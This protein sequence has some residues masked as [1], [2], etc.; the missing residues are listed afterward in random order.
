MADSDEEMPTHKAVAELAECTDLPEQVVPH[1]ALSLARN[2][3]I[4]EQA[5]NKYAVGFVVRRGLRFIETQTQTTLRQFLME[6]GDIIQTDDVVHLLAGR[7]VYRGNG[8]RQRKY[9]LEP[10]NADCDKFISAEM[11]PVLRELFRYVA[12]WE[13]DF[14]DMCLTEDWG[15]LYI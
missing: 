5:A 15:E 2:L 6:Y 4:A 3:R 12:D 9:K 13:C 7:T 10:V 14:S 1:V 8:K 11:V